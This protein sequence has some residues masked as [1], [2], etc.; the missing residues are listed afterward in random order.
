MALIYSNV[1]IYICLRCKYDGGTRRGKYTLVG[2][3]LH[4]G[5][6][7]TLKCMLVRGGMFCLRIRIRSYHMVS[8]SI[9]T[10]ADEN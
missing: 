1:Y 6:S 2:K 7:L 8:F 5:D 9:R 3:N 10:Y 4:R